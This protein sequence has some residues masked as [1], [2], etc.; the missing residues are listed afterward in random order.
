MEFFEVYTAFPE[1]LGD[2]PRWVRA[3][4]WVEGDDANGQVLADHQRDRERAVNTLLE[5]DINMN[6]RDHK[7][8][9]A[10]E[11]ATDKITV[12]FAQGVREGTLGLCPSKTSEHICQ[13]NA[14]L[15]LGSSTKR[16]R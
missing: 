2:M 10:L 13:K 6:H 15:D 1:H 9:P 4:N 3:A 8:K 7:G 12:L 5:H 16:L 11:C 14:R